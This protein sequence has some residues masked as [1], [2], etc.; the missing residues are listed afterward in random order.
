M[1][2][3]WVHMDSRLPPV[4]CR[5]TTAASRFP[6]STGL[7]TKAAGRSWS[8]DSQETSSVIKPSSS[9]LFRAVTE[10]SGEEEGILRRSANT[11]MAVFRSE[12]RFSCAV[13]ET[14]LEIAHGISHMICHSNNF[15]LTTL[16][17]ECGLEGHNGEGTL[18]HTSSQFGFQWQVS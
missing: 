2:N 17:P 16:P 4:P 13:S 10:T 12:K 6:A 1:P 5:Q 11:F 7:T 8:N 9:F 3:F 14:G 15:R 18:A